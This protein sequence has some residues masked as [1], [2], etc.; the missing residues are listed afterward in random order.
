MQCPIKQYLCGI[1][2]SQMKRYYLE[3][4]SSSHAHFFKNYLNEFLLLLFLLLQLWGSNLNIAIIFLLMFF[5]FSIFIAAMR[6]SE[7]YCS[8]AVLKCINA[9][10]MLAVD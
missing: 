1:N 3:S 10:E 5:M 7:K 2:K 8:M 6:Q 9:K 4:P